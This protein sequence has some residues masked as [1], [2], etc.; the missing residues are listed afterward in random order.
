[1]LGWLG[2]LFGLVNSNPTASELA[3]DISSGVDKM[4]YTSEEKAEASAKA[5]EGWLRM[6]E[7]MKG[8][9]QYRSITRRILAVGIVVNLLLMIWICIA[10]EICATF[11]WLGLAS[12]ESGFT[13][14]TLSIIK[15]AAVFQLGWVFC[16]IIVFFFG[17]HLIQFFSKGKASQ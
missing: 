15:I 11:G 10:A 3:G 1:M 6:V 7:M 8:S 2:G 13:S 16:T 5:F 12:I 9:E 4:F 14:I 17:P